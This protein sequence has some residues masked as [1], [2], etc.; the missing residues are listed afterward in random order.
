[1][2]AHRHRTFLAVLALALGLAL[3]AGC[4][5]KADAKKGADKSG[6]TGSSSSKSDQPAADPG[7]G[8]PK[9]GEC[10]QL[11]SA[12]SLASVSTSKVVSCKAAHTSVVSYV[13]YLKVPVTPK[14][15]VRQRQALGLRVCEPAY[16]RLAGGTLADRATSILTWTLFTPDQTQLEHGARWVRCDVIARGGAKLIVLPKSTPLLA[17]G[18]PENL[19]VCQTATGSDVSCS[20]AHAFRLQAV[21]LAAGG[22]KGAHPAYPNTA[23]YTATARARCQQLTGKAGGYW[24]P[25]SRA[26]WIAGDHF[27]RCLT[28]TR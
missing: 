15:P 25:P 19:R 16:R 28:P 23:R 11:T 20:Q 2:P 10:H 18:V 6:S 5:G 1:M 17:Q 13:G 27:I 22:G 9:A 12:Q 14:T 3:L 8:A 7:Y 21:Y 4:G 24:Q 26:G